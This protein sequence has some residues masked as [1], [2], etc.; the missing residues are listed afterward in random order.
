MV[1]PLLRET[2]LVGL[3]ELFSPLPQAF[4]ERDERTLE[5]L[6]GRILNNLERAAQPPLPLL[7]SEPFAVPEIQ[8]IIPE[9][10]ENSIPESSIPQN[11]ITQNAISEV[12]VPEPSA[13]RGFDALTWALRIAVLVCA[14]M[15][16]LLLGRHFSTPK[17]VVRSHP[18]SPASAGPRSA[19]ST[20]PQ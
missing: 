6:A 4:G 16:G 11:S 12:T 9:N 20:P 5:A 19:A 18:V 14:V 1:M 8:Q 10:P 13:E 17:V 7:Q 2:E 15:L 3:F